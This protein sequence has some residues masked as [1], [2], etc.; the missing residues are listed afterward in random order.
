VEKKE[1]II[2]NDGLVWIDKHFLTSEEE[3]FF[4]KSLYKEVKWE[5]RTIKMF[6]KTML[7]P[8]LIGWYGDSG[9]KYRYSGNDFVASN[10]TSSLRSLKEKVENRL[11]DCFNSALINLYENGEHSMSW[12]SDDEKELGENPTIASISLGETRKFQFKHK[13]IKKLINIELGGGSLLYMGGETQHF[14]K[15]A[16]PKQKKIIS[17]RI[18]IT[19]RKVL[20]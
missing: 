7:Q 5:Q 16:L 18:N 12:H 4:F 11:G 1:V 2:K 10:W 6:G 13:I 19:F 9:I 17:P 3:R 20:C 8:R 15:H 14:W